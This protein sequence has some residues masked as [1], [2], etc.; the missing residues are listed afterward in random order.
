MTHLFCFEYQNVFQ[1]HQQKK[2]TLKMF[3]AKNVNFLISYF[4]QFLY[5]ID[6]DLMMY[7][8]KFKNCKSQFWIAIILK[9][10]ILTNFKFFFEF[11][12]TL[13]KMWCHLFVF[14]FLLIWP[15][16]WIFFIMFCCCLGLHH[17]FLQTFIKTNFLE[18]KT[19]KSF[20]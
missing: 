17:F 13:I 9:F 16:F 3:N 4:C 5:L 15:H 6:D 12:S 7:I 19:D 14:V 8:I 18:K 20:L 1:N 11:F 10:L 2:T